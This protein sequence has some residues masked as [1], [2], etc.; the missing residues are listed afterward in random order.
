[1]MENRDTRL[2][3]ELHKGLPPQARIWAEQISH[4]TCSFPRINYEASI[5]RAP[6][7]CSRRGWIFLEV[8]QRRTFFARYVKRTRDLSSTIRR[9]AEQGRNT[10]ISG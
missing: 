3:N 2:M 7:P 9:R 4:G 10:P 6:R 8:G 5:S 1:M